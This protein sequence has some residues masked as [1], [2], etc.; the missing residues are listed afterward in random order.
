MLLLSQTLPKYIGNILLQMMYFRGF[1]MRNPNCAVVELELAATQIELFIPEGVFSI[2]MQWEIKFVLLLSLTQQ[3]HK[4]T[5]PIQMVYF[6]YFSIKN[7]I[8]AIVESKSTITQVEFVIPEDV[9]PSV[10]R[11][12]IQFVLLLSQTQQQHKGDIPL[13]MTY[14]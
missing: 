13:Q 3:Q 4:R 9:F 10:L 6:S 1:V 7:A 12:N 11:W 2:V 8:C 5:L 14:Y